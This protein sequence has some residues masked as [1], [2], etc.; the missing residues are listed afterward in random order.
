MCGIAGII[1]QKPLP[2]DFATFCNLG[3]ANDR[4]GGDSC[5]VFIDGKV[6]YGID[7]TKLFED[8]MFESKVLFNTRVSQIAL[9]HCR[10]AS[11]GLKTKDQAQPVVIY[12]KENKPIFV[13]IHNGTIYNY[14]ELAK[15]YIPT[16]NIEGLTDSQVMARIFFHSGY[17]VLKEYEGGSVFVIVDYREE[18]PEIYL[19]K[20]ASKTSTIDK[21]LTEER[22]LYVAIDEEK[23]QLTFSSIVSNLFACRY[24]IRPESMKPNILYKFTGQTLHAEA[25]YE[26]RNV[27]QSKPVTSY[28]YP[29]YNA[30]Y[31]TG[32][33][34]TPTT[35]CIYWNKSSLKFTYQGNLCHGFKII[36]RAGMVYSTEFTTTKKCWF[37]NG[38][39]LRDRK[40]FEA[41][42]KGWKRSGQEISEFAASNLCKIAYLSEYKIYTLN[43]RVYK[44]TG[45]QSSEIF[46]GKVKPLGESYTDI[47]ANGYYVRTTYDSDLNFEE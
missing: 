5:G 6:E 29:N 25:V 46:T 21:E 7:K 15:K 20:G 30:Y 14:K 42:V 4:R 22:P 45:P 1:N 9:L 37:F 27:L 12:D 47:F 8:F 17:N 43:G 26:R 33:T 11:V 32:S 41:V 39:L 13:V 28:Y 10:K 3:I 2:F 23:N 19:F 18:T 24:W 44:A 34:T 36:G 16:E 35:T 40:C 38:I 31:T